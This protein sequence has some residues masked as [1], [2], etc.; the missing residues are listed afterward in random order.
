MEKNT[1][2]KGEAPYLSPLIGFKNEYSKGYA[3]MRFT[4][5]LPR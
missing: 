3:S 4:K 5:Q 2:I 1:T